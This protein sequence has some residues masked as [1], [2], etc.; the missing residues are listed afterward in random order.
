MKKITLSMMVIAVL[1]AVMGCQQPTSPTVTT[2]PVVTPETPTLHEISSISFTNA[3]TVS[4]NAVKVYQYKYADGSASSDT[5]YYLSDGTKTDLTSINGIYMAAGSVV[6]VNNMYLNGTVEATSYTVGT[7]Y[8][9]NASSS[10]VIRLAINNAGGYTPIVWLITND[11]GDTFFEVEFNGT[12]NYWNGTADGTIT[13]GS[14]T[15]TWTGT[16]N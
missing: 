4:D 13:N 8:F 9:D 11:N 7:N 5:S 2:D 15:W 10:M 1:M 14:V 3:T 12:N 6:Y 16:L